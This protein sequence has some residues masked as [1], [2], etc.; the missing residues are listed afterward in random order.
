MML[1]YLGIDKLHGFM[2]GGV[3]LAVSYITCKI[4]AHSNL[5]MLAAM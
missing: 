4:I 3:R 5:Q 2:M 1:N